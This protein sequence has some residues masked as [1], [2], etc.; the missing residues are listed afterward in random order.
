MYWESSGTDEFHGAEPHV[1][2]HKLCCQNANAYYRDKS[3]RSR[4]CR[5]ARNSVQHKWSSDREKKDNQ[6]PLESILGIASPV[7]KR[8]S[9]RA[10]DLL[11]LFRSTLRQDHETEMLIAMADRSQTHLRAMNRV[12]PE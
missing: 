8:R 4:Y 11:Q 9:T 3:S 1:Y 2:S 6:S 10:A 7:A 5:S 12:C